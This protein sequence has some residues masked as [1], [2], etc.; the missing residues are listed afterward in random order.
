MSF[1]GTFAPTLFGAAG[2]SNELSTNFNGVDQ[3]IQFGNAFSYTNNLSVF[4]W[5]STRNLSSNTSVFSKW[6]AGIAQRSWAIWI[7][8]GGKLRVAISADGGTTNQKDY[9]NNAA[10]TVENNGWHLVGFTFASN[11]LKLYVDGAEVTTSK[12]TDPTVNAIHA[13]T[14]DIWMGKDRNFSYAYFP[15]KIDEPTI[16]T[17][18]V[19]SGADVA[20]LYNS[21]IPSNPSTLSLSGTLAHWW[22]LGDGDDATT[23]YDQVASADGTLANMDDSNYVTNYPGYEYSLNSTT[24]NGVDEYITVPDDASLD[25]T[26]NL[27]VFFWVKSSAA[28]VFEALIS[29]YHFTTSQK[30]WYV[31]LASRQLRV[32]ISDDGAGTNVKDY[33]TTGTWI[34]NGTWQHVGFTF[35]NNDLKLWVD[36]V[37]RTSTKTTDNTVTAI[38]ASTTDLEIGSLLNNPSYFPGQL[39]EV[40][41]WNSTLGASEIVK[42]YNSGAPI[43]LKKNNGNYTSSANLVSYYRMGD[44]DDA[45]NLYDNKGTNDGT[46]V[47]MNAS[48]YTTDVP[49]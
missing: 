4:C 42:I 6:N 37:D 15:G 3:T 29:K 38:N 5:V 2:F 31:S 44:G 18:T 35:S 14:T 40:A 13:G 11:V 26:T 28:G 47:N 30:S 1:P 9:T 17:G 45:T 34:A 24:F 7:T 8:A 32:Y 41:I 46:L 43:D 27:S 16:W 20:A 10:G 33:V 39:D 36:G 25:I 12:G 48:N 19:L 49:L 22:R 23:V 21:G